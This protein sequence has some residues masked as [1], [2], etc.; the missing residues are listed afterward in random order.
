MFFK[1]ESLRSVFPTLNTV[2][3]LT[4]FC[5]AADFAGRLPVQIYTSADRL[6]SGFVNYIMRDSHGFI[7]ACTHAATF[8]HNL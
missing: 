8:E 1:T 7:R 6:G 2:F 3:C 5:A 4:I